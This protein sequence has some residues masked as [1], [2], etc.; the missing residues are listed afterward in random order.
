MK[1]QVGLTAVLGEK[2]SIRDQGDPQRHLDILSR[3]HRVPWF[4]WNGISEQERD[5]GKSRGVVV[6]K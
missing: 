5:R 6:V 2:P 4:K 1:A 3:G